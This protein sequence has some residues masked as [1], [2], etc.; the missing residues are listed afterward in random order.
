M[1]RNIVARHMISHINSNIRAFFYFI[2]ILCTYSTRS[3]RRGLN[4]SFEGW[5]FIFVLTDYYLEAAW[6]YLR[7]TVFIHKFKEGKIFYYLKPIQFKDSMTWPFLGY[8]SNKWNV[9][10]YLLKN[11]L[12]N[13]ISLNITHINKSVI[14]AGANFMWTG[15]T[16]HAFKVI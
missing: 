16:I 7:P 13:Y 10:L 11:T 8:D 14:Y 12:K 2:R 6:L 9:F 5:K 4:F 1:A 3:S 15:S